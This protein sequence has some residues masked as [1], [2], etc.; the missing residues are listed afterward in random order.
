MMAG[1]IRSRLLTAQRGGEL[2]GAKWEEFDLVRV[3][4]S[5]SR[6]EAPARAPRPEGVER[7]V[8][9]AALDFWGDPIE[10]IIQDGKTGR[11]L[12]FEARRFR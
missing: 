6:E 10:A 8:E 5:K 2:L 3:G 4:V 11:V 9:R 12:R 1:L 7:L